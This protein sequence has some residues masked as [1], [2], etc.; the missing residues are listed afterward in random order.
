[1]M[2]RG[3]TSLPDLGS[4]RS[5][6]RSY[7]RSRSREDVEVADGSFRAAAASSRQQS[8]ERSLLGAF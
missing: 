3:S 2:A 7:A 8:R 4:G 1:M 5:T 6:G